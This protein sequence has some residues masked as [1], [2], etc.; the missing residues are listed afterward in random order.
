MAD[1]PNRSGRG[2]PNTLDNNDFFD[3]ESIGRRAGRH[4]A[5]DIAQRVRLA[6]ARS[7]I[8][9]YEAALGSGPSDAIAAVLSKELASERK[10]VNSLGPRI[11]LRQETQR[12]R[13][14]ALS[15]NRIERA[16]TERAVNSISGDFA[17]STSGQRI[18][19][20]MMGVPYEE[21]E[22]RRSSA[23]NNIGQL[24]QRAMGISEG[25]YNERGQQDPGKMAQLQQIYAQR[26]RVINQ[27]GAI[28]AAQ[29]QQRGQGM[30]P[31]SQLESLYGMGS[32]A[33]R[34]LFKIGI[35]E[36][37]RSGT[38]DLGGKSMEQLRQREA[39]LSK[40]LVDELEKLRNATGKTTEEL[41][42]MKGAATQTAE[43]LKKTEEAI[44]QAGGGG[45]R[46]SNAANWMSFAGGVFGS[47][48][49]G[50]Q[51][52]AVNQRIGQVANISGYAAIENQK[53]AAYQKASGG[54]VASQLLLSQFGAAE[55]FGRELKIGANA[56]VGLGVAASGAQT[57]SGGIRTLSTANPL[58]NAIGTSS[59]H[60][61]R[62][63]GL[64]DTVQGLTGGAVGG[65]D[66]YRGVSGNAASLAGIEAQMEARRQLMA[67]NASQLQGFRDFGV[68]MGSAA[69]GMGGRGAAFV[70]RMVTKENLGQMTNA[71][72][73]PEQMAHMS[74]VGVNEMGSVFNEGQIFGSRGLE[75]AGFGTMQQNMQRM[76]TLAQ[77]GANNPQ[78]GLA[79]VLEAAFSKGLEGSRVLN[80]VAENTASMVQAS[81]GRAMGID[82]TAASAQILAAGVNTADPNQEY[83][84]QQAA[85]AAERM[86]MIG[87]DTGVNFSA[88]AA[89]ARISKMTGLSGTE[90]II[91][92][93][94]DD[95]TLKS[96]K[97]M[98]PNEIRSSMFDRGI[99]IK[100]GQEKQTIDQLIKARSITNTQLGGAGIGLGVNASAIAEKRAA[101]IPLTHAEELLSNQAGTLAGFAGGSQARRAGG[102]ILSEEPNQVTKAKVAGAMRGEGA[103]DQQKMID[104]MRTQ[105]FKQLSQAAMEATTNFKTAADALK[106]LGAL[107][108]SVENVGDK[109]GEGKFKGAAADAA[110]SFG[111][112]TIMFDKSVNEFSKAITLMVG[113]SGISSGENLDMMNKYIKD[114]KK[115]IGGP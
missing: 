102:A 80:M 35:G 31:K 45:S 8:S 6:Q 36:E 78:A 73:S 42:K 65:M 4:T 16:F 37:L 67:I 58:E 92:Q 47:V 90:A 55:G 23:M 111:A 11:E 76:S 104:D 20:S 13:F 49:A 74:T 100:R 17:R 83:A 22:A 46:A 84:V 103:S 94:L 29:G 38:G 71:R 60:G 52:I 33:E 53:Y 19:M 81:A 95:A 97:G 112:S 105:G 32:R 50:V 24:G 40:Q 59:A 56:A 115:R 54:D 2:T 77:A 107:A 12:E 86:K 85:S 87:T 88:M 101:G 99:D 34:N 28:E 30:D 10:T 18:G 5:E 43:D 26:S 70:Q 72:I 21:L 106:A 114:M 41:E 63:Q 66:L 75:R 69:I 79:S 51:A 3:L 91:A 82:T 15:Q 9:T 61:Q 68:G 93:G 62:L 89:T 113:K 44:S 57:I 110:G 1:D 27:V 108:K 109:G 25:L 64:Q 14:T 7:R 98:N 96:L 48:G 39:Q